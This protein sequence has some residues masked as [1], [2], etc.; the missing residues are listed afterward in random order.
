M[1]KLIIL[2]LCLC[3]SLSFVACAETTAETDGEDFS[4]RV[5]RVYVADGNPGL[6]NSKDEIIFVDSKTGVMYLFIDWGYGGGLTVMV[7]E[8][9]DPLLWDDWEVTE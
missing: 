4:E 9:G 3:M 5:K 1:K 8:N 6:R 7:D 2:I